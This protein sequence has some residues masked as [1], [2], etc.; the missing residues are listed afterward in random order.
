MQPVLLAG[1][2]AQRF[3]AELRVAA[4]HPLPSLTRRSEEGLS[5][6][7]TAVTLVVATVPTAEVACCLNLCLWPRW[8]A[9]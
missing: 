7:H 1:T 6:T 5:W 4:V 8:H 3:R 9:C 2:V